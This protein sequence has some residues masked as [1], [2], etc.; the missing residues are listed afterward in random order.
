MGQQEARKYSINALRALPHGI[1]RALARSDHY[2]MSLVKIRGQ[3]VGVGMRTLAQV[4][5]AALDSVL[6]ILRRHG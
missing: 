4:S 3:L 6:T 5:C 2:F 1:D